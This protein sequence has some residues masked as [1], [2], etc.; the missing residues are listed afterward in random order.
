MSN[1]S[2]QQCYLQVLLVV[3]V[4]WVVIVVLMVVGCLTLI[5]TLLARGCYMYN[6]LTFEGGW[7]NYL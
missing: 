1:S 5:R 3:V 4:L 2:K 7:C 6:I